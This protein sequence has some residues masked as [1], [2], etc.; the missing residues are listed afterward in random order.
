MKL[1]IDGDWLAYSTACALQEDNP[2]DPEAPKLFDFGV[3]KKVVDHKIDKWIDLLD[4]TDTEVHFSCN[5]EDNWRRD[6]LPS[7]KMNRKDKEPPVGLAMMIE[8]MTNKY[9][10]VTVDRLEADDTLGITATSEEDTVLVSVDKDFLTIPTTIYNPMKDVV[11]KQNRVNAFKSFVYQTLIG[12]A[13]DGFKGLHLIG[14]KKALAFI[15]KHEK[16]LYNIWEPM[17]ELAIKQKQDE[18]HLLTQARMAH[19]LQAGDY[20]FETREVRWWTPDL[21]GEMLG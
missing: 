13:T 6:I 9:E 7:Y 17:V 16:A 11:K 12:D 20:N 10:T 21:I 15:K 4:G 2:F 3:A 1:I 19:I 14:P 8:Y 18:E 5:R